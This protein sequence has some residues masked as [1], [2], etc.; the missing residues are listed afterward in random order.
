MDLRVLGW[1]GASV[2]CAELDLFVRWPR[3]AGSMPE[4]PHSLHVQR[5]SLF[6]RRGLVLQGAPA[7]HQQS[8]YC[9]AAPVRLDAAKSAEAPLAPTKP[10]ATTPVTGDGA[11][12]CTRRC[13]PHVASRRK[14][15]ASDK[16]MPG[17]S[18]MRHVRPA[19]QVRSAHCG[20]MTVRAAKSTRKSAAYE[21]R[22]PL[23]HQH[24]R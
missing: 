8:R 1:D 15:S 5:Y 12:P 7:A 22:N 13:T 9:P 4:F 24:K 14:R 10:F 6:G 11:A 19:V 16:C 17:R 18:V 20:P 21:Q 3:R 2:T 23:L